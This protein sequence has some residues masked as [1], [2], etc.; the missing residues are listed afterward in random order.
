[1]NSTVR[2]RVATTA[3]LD[4]VTETVTL[5]FAADP[6][7]SLALA[8]QDGQLD[9]QP[10]LWRLWI[11]GALRYP[12]VWLTDGGA[13]VSVW[14]PPGGTEMSPAQEAAFEHLA[15][16]RLGPVR[17]GYL[18]ETMARFEAAHPRDEPHYYLSLLGTH[19]EYRGR[20]VG[21][22]LLADN[23]AQIDGERMPAHLAS[24]NPANGHRYQRVG[25]EPIGAFNLPADGPVVTKMWRPAQGILGSVPI[26]RSRA[27]RRAPGPR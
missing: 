19:P 22:A 12:W 23:L 18:R 10:G 11:E 15:A 21:M 7:W 25:F 26:S 5:A 4:V 14:I 24:S 6:V 3:D 16:D 13:A 8:G 1:M 20:G 2:P 9:R 27:R 17:S